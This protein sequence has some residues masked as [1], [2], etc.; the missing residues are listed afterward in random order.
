[1]IPNGLLAR[2]DLISLHLSVGWI[3]GS[4]IPSFGDTIGLYV[5]EIMKCGYVDDYYN[6]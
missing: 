3:A 4:S 2:V 6:Q 5:F 1:M